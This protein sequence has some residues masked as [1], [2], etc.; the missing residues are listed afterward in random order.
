MEQTQFDINLI[1]Q[2]AGAGQEDLISQKEYSL[3]ENLIFSKFLL[4]DKRNL[5]KYII[6]SKSKIIIKEPMVF[7]KIKTRNIFIMFL[8]Y[9]INLE[10]RYFKNFKKNQKE[11]YFNNFVYTILGII[12]K[13][14][15]DNLFSIRDIEIILKYLI[16]LSTLSMDKDYSENDFKIKLYPYFY[17]SMEFLKLLFIDDQSTFLKKEEAD[18]SISYFNFISD[19]I[20]SGLECNTF[21]VRKN[22]QHTVT[23][24]E[25]F[26]LLKNIPEE[27]FSSVKNSMLRMFCIIYKYNLSF[28]NLINVFVIQMKYLLI[29]YDKKSLSELKKDVLTSNTS[30]SF[31][32]QNYQE[33]TDSFS[34]DSYLIKEGFYLSGK[35]NGISACDLVFEKKEITM[36]FSFCIS[37]NKEEL[38]EKFTF[39]TLYNSK[40]EIL[41]QI[42]FCLINESKVA[43]EGDLATMLRRNSIKKGPLYRMEILSYTGEKSAPIK[44][45]PNIDQ[46]DPILINRSYL[47]SIGFNPERKEHILNIY[48]SS[49]DRKATQKHIVSKIPQIKFDKNMNLYLGSVPKMT[50]NSEKKPTTNI[51]TFMTTFQGFIGPFIIL[52]ENLDEQTVKNIFLLKGKYENFLIFN[53]ASKCNYLK[54]YIE[55]INMTEYERCEKY[56][57]NQNNIKLEKKKEQYPELV[58]LI[59]S[60][61]SFQF[62]REEKEIIHS[63]PKYYSKEQIE[64]NENFLDVK[65]TSKISRKKKIKL[66]RIFNKD[67][68]IFRNNKNILEFIKSEGF[69]YLC[70]LFEYNFQ[71]LSLLAKTKPGVNEDEATQLERE[72]ITQ[73]ILSQ[74]I[75]NIEEMLDLILFI[76]GQ[77]SIENFAKELKKVF[78]Q[79]SITIHKICELTKNLGIIFRK[80]RQLFIWIRSK[81]LDHFYKMQSNKLA[82]ME[83]KKL[84][85]PEEVKEEQKESSLLEIKNSFFY[86]LLDKNLYSEEDLTSFEE[87]FQTLR[88]DINDLNDEPNRSL[89]SIQFFEKI[90]EYLF[91]L[92]LPDNKQNHPVIEIFSDFLYDLI[93]IITQSI[94]RNREIQKEEDLSSY[95]ENIK[96]KMQQNEEK[97]KKV[98]AK[99][100]QMLNATGDYHN[101]CFSRQLKIFLNSE[102]FLFIQCE[103]LLNFIKIVLQN[104]TDLEEIKNNPIMKDIYSSIVRLLTL[105]YL[106]V[107]TNSNIFQ[108]NKFKPIFNQLNWSY[109]TIYNFICALVYPDN[110]DDRKYFNFE[111]N[112]KQYLMHYSLKKNE[113]FMEIFEYISDILYN[114]YTTDRKM[115][116][117][118]YI[119]LIEFIKNVLNQNNNL[120]YTQVFDMSNTGLIN[121]FQNRLDC[122]REKKEEENEEEIEIFKPS[123]SLEDFYEDIAFITQK[124]YMHPNPFI[125]RFLREI[126]KK[127]EEIS[128]NLVIKIFSL[129]L[130]KANGVQETQVYNIINILSF[131]NYITQLQHSKII[132]TDSVF[133]LVIKL[134][135]VIVDNKFIGYDILLAVPSPYKEEQPENQKFIAE[136]IFDVLLFLKQNYPFE[137]SFIFFAKCMLIESKNSKLNL[138]DEE[139]KFNF[140]DVK[141]VFF[142]IDK[143]SADQAKVPKVK[144]N[145]DF[146]RITNFNTTI[147]ILLKVYLYIFILKEEP[148]TV[149]IL[150]NFAKILASDIFYLFKMGDKKQIFYYHTVSELPLYNNIR[151]CLDDYIKLNN[152]KKFDELNEKV[153]LLL[154]TKM[155]DSDAL[156][157]VQNLYF[158]T[159]SRKAKRSTSSGEFSLGENRNLTLKEG[160]GSANVNHSVLEK[161]SGDAEFNLEKSQSPNETVPSI[162]LERTTS[163]HNTLKQLKAV[164]ELLGTKLEAAKRQSCHEKEKRELPSKSEDTKEEPED[165]WK[166]NDFEELSEDF[167]IFSPKRQILLT[168]FGIFFAD[169]YFDN[170]LFHKLKRFYCNS[171]QANMNT[172]KLRFPSKFK[173]FSNGY[174]P[175]LFLKQDFEFF[176]L[177]EKPNPKKGE[178]NFPSFFGVTHKYFLDHVKENEIKQIKFFPKSINTLYVPDTS[179]KCELISPEGS[180]F[181]ELFY[182]SKFLYFTTSKTDL[183]ESMDVK[184]QLN[185]MLSCQQIDFISKKKFSLIFFKNIKEILHKR[186]LYLEHAVEIYTKSGKSYFFNFFKKQYAKIFFKFIETTLEKN[187]DIY[188]FNI[189]PIEKDFMKNKKYTNEWKMGR[190]STYD[191]LLLINKYSTR[192]FR[193][194]NQ[195]PIFPWLLNNYTAL[196]SNQSITHFISKLDKKIQLEAST[197]EAPILRLMKYPISIQ[198]STQ[199]DEAIEKFREMKDDTKFPSH[200]GNHYSTSSYVYY[201]LMR[202]NPHTNNI[203]KLQNYHRE[204]PNRTFIKFSDSLLLLSSNRDNRELVP[205]IFSGIEYMINLNCNFFGIRSDGKIVDDMQFENE[206]KIKKRKSSIDKP[207]K[208]EKEKY[209]ELPQYANFLIKHRQLLNSEV[210]EKIL[211]KWIDLIYGVGQINTTNHLLN[212]KNC[213]IFS[214]YSYEQKTDLRKKIKKHFGDYSSNN[215]LTDEQKVKLKRLKNKCCFVINF[216]QCPSVIFKAAH[217]KKTFLDEETQKEESFLELV[218]EIHT[219]NMKGYVKKPSDSEIIFFNFN[220]DLRYLYTLTNNRTFDLF[221]VKLAND[222]IKNPKS[223][224]QI[225]LKKF[226]FFKNKVHLAKLVDKNLPKGIQSQNNQKLFMANP[227]YTLIDIFDMKYIISCKYM[228]K[229]FKLQNIPHEKEKAIINTI[230]FDSFVNTICKINERQFLVGLNNG[231]LIEYHL[232]ENIK[233][234][235]FIL[236][237][238]RSVFAHKKAISIIE[239]VEKLGVIITAGEDGY[240]YIRK[241]FDFELLTVIK[242]KPNLKCQKIKVSNNNLLYAL[243]LDEKRLDDRQ[244]KTEEKLSLD[245]GPYC[246]YCY[247]LSGMNISC[248]DYGYFNNFE[249]T[250]IGNIICLSPN[251][252][253]RNEVKELKESKD[254]GI[255]NDFTFIMVLNGG[256]LKKKKKEYTLSTFL[257]KEGLLTEFS[258]EYLKNKYIITWF[259]YFEKLKV[260]IFSYNNNFFSIELKNKELLEYFE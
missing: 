26:Y 121:I 257:K 82:K 153:K 122:Y 41:F 191:Y 243:F 190:L 245:Q 255:E 58:D 238:K 139:I 59:I 73:D 195:Y 86:L 235:K 242:L 32:V 177:S 223:E 20:L 183:R 152:I 84:T 259:N 75:V 144:G 108:E 193:D 105:L 15:K 12:A 241:I 96:E 148:G 103:D 21:L 138:N 188:D 99:F 83:E 123:S 229:S 140:K 39:L 37:Q 151:K 27:S 44:I 169:V 256:D 230:F 57:I 215:P 220:K 194:I 55:D 54:N 14:Y 90:S 36:L 166:I 182:C 125:F 157:F 156:T 38:S 160:N 5:M 143:I 34:N 1:L 25:L 161:H 17:Y 189:I 187:K 64:K 224:K 202:S 198:T 184:D 2:K 248:S 258:K 221:E 43:I 24:F 13:L 233:K 74:V 132:F 94:R 111:D 173:N 217:P 107:I 70:L 136:I 250:S 11:K 239:I 252:V 164:D 130:E 35:D 201:F 91:I 246:I 150:T 67:F 85:Q 46:L 104:Y 207:E 10:D 141:T 142:S 4:W 225:F 145:L 174:Y 159:L 19:K 176:D 186:F 118:S 244:L 232:K 3:Y 222:F 61:K 81:N 119:F 247:T 47:F 29:N 168:N 214:K 120:F 231:L 114:L 52:S 213:N 226:K 147:Y 23:F 253:M 134:F 163:R 124:L 42:N 8:Y 98:L 171:F 192:T 89:I 115:Y 51:F 80:L 109:L 154:N 69:S 66:S 203:I 165:N 251:L 234:D 237:R 50:Q 137:D 18:L 181:G 110:K 218:Q 172:K 212:E 170:D 204:D 185:Y 48:Y 101:I 72:K 9:S 79:M 95:G 100:F 87:L 62:V 236:T 45:I 146:P 116:E 167:S 199:R 216:G 60:P 210:I 178:P 106:G 208:E 53:E 71:I 260:F 56:F 76:L 113:K 126:S 88:N 227:G 16:C 206:D 155:K 77:I 49:S 129:L 40:E 33:E 92:R 175:P 93:S 102:A 97:D 112:L 68:H 149:K 63:E 65:S 228:D 7:N 158:S 127:D 219:K 133:K 78:F 22:L 254:K 179:L 196:E 31:L 117:E 197:E 249:F 30:I 240:I 28:L 135:H 209:M 211:P 180:I 162:Y 131:L 6:E 205:D 200:L 128:N